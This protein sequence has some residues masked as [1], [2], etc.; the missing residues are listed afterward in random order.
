MIK[1][2]CLSI[3]PLFAGVRSAFAVAGLFEFGRGAEAFSYVAVIDQGAT[4]P[5]ILI[6]IIRA[7]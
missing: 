7:I 1:G 6:P 3:K 4:A 2:A 5:A